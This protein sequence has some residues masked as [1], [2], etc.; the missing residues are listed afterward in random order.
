MFTLY[1]GWGYSDRLAQLLYME[2]KNL[3]NG[4]IATRKRHLME[5]NIEEF[6]YLLQKEEWTKVFPSDVPNASFKIFTHTFSYYFNTV[7]PLTG[8]YIAVPAVKIRITKGI[9]VS[10][11]K[12]RLLSS[13]KR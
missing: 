13:I 5:K 2:S 12:L 6:Q 7:F 4:P 10:T 8:T 3:Q 11:N 9:I 1:L